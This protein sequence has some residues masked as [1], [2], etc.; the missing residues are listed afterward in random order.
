M[1]QDYIPK[2]W[3]YTT[4]NI[5]RNSFAGYYNI[6]DIKEIYIAIKYVIRIV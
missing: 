1:K 2:V 4:T 3:K 5:A 6:H